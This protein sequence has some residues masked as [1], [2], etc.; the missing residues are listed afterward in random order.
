[1]DATFI[2]RNKQFNKL[3]DIEK[4]EII[5]MVRKAYLEDNLGINELIDKF[6]STKSYM[7]EFLRNY[8]I[9]KTKEQLNLERS[10]SAKKS[11]ASKTE[12]EM[13]A[14]KDKRKKTNLKRFGVENCYQSEEIKQRIKEICLE[15]YGVEHHNQR[16]D[17]KRKIDENTI[18]SQGA[19]R[20][21]QTDIGQQK[22]R[23]TCLEKYGVEN[24]FQSEE[25]KNKIKNTNLKKYGY[26]VAIKSSIVKENLK[27]NNRLKYNVDYISQRPEIQ[28]KVKN[29][30]MERYGVPWYC[31]TENCK[32]AQG[33]CSNF[34][35]RFAELLDVN[36][37]QYKRELSLETFTYDFQIDNNL[38]ELNPTYTHNSTKGPYFNKHYTEPKD[39]NYHLNKSSVAQKYGYRC[40]HI[41]DWDD[42]NKIINLFLPKTVVYARKCEIKEVKK[43]EVNNFLNLYH[44]QDTCNGQKYCYG[45]YYENQLIELMTFGKPRYNKNYEYELLRLCTHKDYKVVGGSERL[46]KHFLKESCPKS[47]ISYCDNS[48]FSGDVYERLGMD[49]INTSGPACIWSKGKIK[50]TDNLLRQQGFDRL[51]NTNYGKGTSNRDL[52]INEGFV[53]VYDCGQK[54]YEY[55]NKSI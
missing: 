48:K 31:M 1:M 25:K 19:K 40:I 11:Y 53:E 32:M 15:K 37:I 51:F 41:F 55:I 21:L 45:L 2:L 43:S 22:Y 16:E 54:S 46:F 39:K 26:T 3:S 7:Y 50:I 20:Y 44:L 18:K 34:N 4:Q 28:E 24:T 29:T 42:V 12:D 8:N 52:I 38:I 35:N 6:N 27:H 23:N 5:K 36:N 17:V 47:I 9:K 33:G 14:I 49:L 30:N 13:N 10:I